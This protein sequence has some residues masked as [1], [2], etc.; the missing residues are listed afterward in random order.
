M[1][2]LAT[3]LKTFLVDDLD[4][5]DAEADSPKIENARLRVLVTELLAA[6]TSETTAQAF[7]L[8]GG[9]ALTGTSSDASSGAE[10][11]PPSPCSADGAA[12][13]GVGVAERVANLNL[14]FTGTSRSLGLLTE[15]NIDPKSKLLAQKLLMLI[16]RHGRAVEVI[17]LKLTA[18][19]LGVLAAVDGTHRSVGGEAPTP[20]PPDGEDADRADDSGIGATL[21]REILAW[22]NIADNLHLPRYIQEKMSTHF[23]PHKPMGM[24]PIDEDMADAL[25]RQVCCTPPPVPLGVCSFVVL[26]HLCAFCFR[27]CVFVPLFCFV[28]S[29]FPFAA[30]HTFAAIC[31]FVDICLY[32]LRFRS[33][34]LLGVT[35]LFVCFRSACGRWTLLKFHT[36]IRSCA[37]V[38][39]VIRALVHS[40]HWFI[41]SCP[42]IHSVICART[43]VW[44]SL[45]ARLQCH[46][47]YRYRQVGCDLQFVP[48]S[49]T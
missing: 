19:S 34:L 44:I 1:R 31:A 27:V 46:L 24:V 18:G 14:L 20:E 30:T 28:F 29:L 40:V 37:H 26:V 42:H 15:Q 39:L 45:H 33:T 36:F 13:F 17:V 16:A 43:C 23:T 22:R 48:F 8:A 10:R 35:L 49:W 38:H 41:R 5:D 32:V 11:Q 4:K 7:E 3:K 12:A 47:S 2:K 21:R 6:V 9:G 25:N